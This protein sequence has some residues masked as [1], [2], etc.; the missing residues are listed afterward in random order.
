M[1]REPEKEEEPVPETVIR[2]LPASTAK[3][4]EIL[5]VIPVLEAISKKA[6]GVESPKPNRPREVLAKIAK[7]EPALLFLNS[8]S[9]EREASF[10]HFQK[11]VMVWTIL[12]KAGSL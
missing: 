2:L 11:P 7:I 5:A 12:H 8:T 9:L 6:S 3:I 4:L 1:V 10:W